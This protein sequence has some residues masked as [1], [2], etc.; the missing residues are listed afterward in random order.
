MTIRQRK[1]TASKQ[2]L[3]NLSQYKNLSDDEFDKVFEEVYTNDIEESHDYDSLFEKLTARI[4]EKI[5][6]LSVDYDLS[7]MKANDMMQLQSMVAAMTHLEDLEKEVYKRSLQ[8]TDENVYTIEKLNKIMSDLRADISKISADL[9]L[10]KKARNQNTDTSILQRWEELKQKAYSF[11]TQKM[12]YIFCPEC[13]HLLSTVWLLYTENPQNKLYL[14]CEH[15]GNVFEQNLGI[16]YSSGNKN[17]VDV[18]IP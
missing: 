8:I 2:R 5:D 4:N 11:Y 6:K 9:Q 18:K 16:L 7:D 14:H 12:L 3:R 15:C 10:T 17:L 13:R 1:F